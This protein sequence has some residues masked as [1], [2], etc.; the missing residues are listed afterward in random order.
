[1]ALSIREQPL[2]AAFA[3]AL[4]AL[5]AGCEKKTTTTETSSG[6]VTT[7]ILSPS[8]EASQAIGRVNETLAKAASAIESSAAASQ[9]LTQVGEAVEDGVITAKVKAALLVDPDVKGL[10]VDVD[11]RD[12][13]VTLKGSADKAASRDNAVRIARDTRG[14]KS[15]DSQLVVR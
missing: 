1:M 3:L 5:L 10:Q 13:V 14:V 9:A 4:A 8:P 12:G 15:V 2:I 6:P 7:T 11:T